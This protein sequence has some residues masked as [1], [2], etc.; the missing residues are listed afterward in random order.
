MTRAAR[1]CDS[2]DR[3]LEV[4]RLRR[5][6]LAWY[7]RAAR[8]LPWRRRAA[9]PYAQWL[10][11]MMLQQT[12]SETVVRYYEPFLDRFP[13]VQALA[14]APLNAV[15][16]RWAGMGYYA[17]AR[18][19]HRAA[20]DIVAR[21]A[22]RVPRT[23]EELLTL[24]GVGR[25]TAG[26]VAS[27]AYGVRAPIL[28][29]NVARVLTR[30]YA[31][32]GN[33]TDRTVRDEL[34]RR[35]A[36]SLPRKRC[37][38]FNQAL[39]DLGATVCTPRAPRCPQCPLRTLCLAHAVGRENDLPLRPRRTPVRAVAIAVLAVQCG[40]RLLLRQRPRDG[41]WGG[42]WEVP[43]E[44]AHAPN[45]VLDRLVPRAVAVR[46]R[47]IHF[48]GRVERLLTHRRMRFDV[49]RT[50]VSAGPRPRVRAPYAWVRP[51]D[52]GDRP[53]SRAQERILT[54]LG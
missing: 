27:I 4:A 22:G 38:E 25:Y 45:E 44:E 41:L 15:L 12:R 28:D 13:T 24:P 32:E 17:R 39:M 14:A 48:V 19:L 21:F 20:R 1:Q 43:G 10:A 51:D 26:A 9:D 3:P 47:A 18:N 35:A 30:L 23:V 33:P 54:L 16:Q 50:E 6:L 46:L 31:L 42:L 11:E 29:G 40:D 53:L 49:Y 34:W 8:D 36:E 7:D 52:Q 2:C 37:G 5:R